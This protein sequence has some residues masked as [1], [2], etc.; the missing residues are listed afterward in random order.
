MPFPLTDLSLVRAYVT[1]SRYSD[2]DF[3][4]II[5]AATNHTKK[6]KNKNKRRHFKRD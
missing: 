5:V 4:I 2:A 3:I 6:N 1:P